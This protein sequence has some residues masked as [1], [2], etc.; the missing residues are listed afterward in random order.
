MTNHGIATVAQ[1]QD[2]ANALAT[3][4]KP[5]GLESVTLGDMDMSYTRH[6]IGVEF[7]IQAEATR[8]PIAYPKVTPAPED[9]TTSDWHFMGLDPETGERVYARAGA[10]RRLEVYRADDEPAEP[11]SVIDRTSPEYAALVAEAQRGVRE[12]IRLQNEAC[13]RALEER[14]DPARQAPRACEYRPMISV[15]TQ[16]LE[17]R[18]FRLYEGDGDPVLALER[19][20]S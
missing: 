15:A 11:A 19:D 4:L 17:P 14:L 12:I 1:A 2:I 9:E 20:C 3:A 16:P 6:G 8:V 13:R 7:T 10:G 5:F 18:K